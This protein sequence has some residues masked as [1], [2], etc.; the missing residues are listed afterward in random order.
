LKQ[1]AEKRGIGNTFKLYQDNDPKHKA[2][3]V[4]SWLFF[5]VVLKK[6]P[7]IKVSQNVEFFVV[8]V[9]SYFYFL[10]YPYDMYLDELVIKKTL[11]FLF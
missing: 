3:K 1:S 2:Y 7:N 8:Y 10:T 5:F 6:K 9:C 11:I 4:K